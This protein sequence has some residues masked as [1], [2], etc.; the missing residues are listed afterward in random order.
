MVY[1]IADFVRQS[2]SG[3]FSPDQVLEIITRVQERDTFQNAL[4]QNNYDF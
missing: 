2:T 3:G 1:G 4:S